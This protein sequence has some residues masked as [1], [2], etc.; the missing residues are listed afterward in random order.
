[1]TPIASA[2]MTDLARN[3][4]QSTQSHSSS[5]GEHIYI[6]EKQSHLL[7]DNSMHSNNSSNTHDPDSS[8]Y[9]SG[10]SPAS[11]TLPPVPNI[12][13]DAGVYRPRYLS[14]DTM[15]DTPPSNPTYPLTPLG[16]VDTN[17]FPPSYQSARNHDSY[18]SIQTL[19]PP[20]P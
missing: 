17:D 9:T 5:N 2:S 20:I 8:M 3:V 13:I 6:D 12:N 15:F 18:P 19:P 7:R 1:M 16:P 4:S 11:Y 10:P 14:G